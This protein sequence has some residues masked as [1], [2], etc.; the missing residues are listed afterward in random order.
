MPSKTTIAI[1]IL[2]L[3]VGILSIAILS[4]VAR[5]VILT[6]TSSISAIYPANAKGTGR[7]LLFWPGVGGIVDMLLFMFLWYLTPSTNAQ[8]KKRTAFWNGIL[9]VASFIF[10]RP[11]IVLI[12][13]FVEL[14]GAQKGQ[15]MASDGGYVTTET[16][17]CAASNKGVGKAG[18]ICSEIR[19]AR[20][21]LIPGLGF[22]AVMLGL[23]IYKRVQLSRESR[24]VGRSEV[25][26]TKV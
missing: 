22:A 5:S 26:S 2:N 17:A 13:V 11:L 12:Y 23:V 10:G 8:P 3:V 7:G 25:G 24:A 21:L 14:N 18:S 9:F 6:D 15:T 16:W 20:Y 19:T 1:H 4:L